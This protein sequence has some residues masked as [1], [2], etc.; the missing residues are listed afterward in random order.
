MG[1]FQEHYFMEEGNLNQG[2]GV[3]GGGGEQ[4]YSVYFCVGCA[5]GTLLPMSYTR[6]HLTDFAT[7]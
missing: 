7:L 5:A 1:N 4:G 6:P 2:V 3:G